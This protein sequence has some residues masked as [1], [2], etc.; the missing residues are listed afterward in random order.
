MDL[1]PVREPVCGFLAD[2]YATED[3][4]ARFEFLDGFVRAR[5]PE[6]ETSAGRLEG[7]RRMLRLHPDS[8]AAADILQAARETTAGRET[9]RDT[10]SARRENTSDPVQRNQ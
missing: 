8:K 3:D 10:V 9:E 4:P 7:A 5:L 2:C 6:W 1:A